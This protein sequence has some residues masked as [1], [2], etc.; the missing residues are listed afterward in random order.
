MMDFFK[1]R[2]NEAGSPEES[3]FGRMI[4]GTHKD[5]SGRNSRF[6]GLGNF[7]RAWNT[8]R[9]KANLSH[10]H[11]HDTRHVSAT[12]LIDNGTPEQVVMTVAGWK[13]NML[14]TYYHR[15]PKRALEL[16]RFGKKCED[17]VKTQM[18][19]AG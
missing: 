13:T 4:N 16:V 1:R 6:V 12:D 11:F 14:K 7:F 8:V 3:V 19:Q 5:R 10:I 18:K 15:E 2:K 9:R 17:D